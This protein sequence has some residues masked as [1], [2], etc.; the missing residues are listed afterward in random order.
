MFNINAW[1]IHTNIDVTEFISDKQ[2]GKQPHKVF[3][4]EI[5]KALVVDS[6]KHGQTLQMLWFHTLTVNCTAQFSFFYISTVDA[7][8]M[9]SLCAR[10]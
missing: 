9:R 1:S 8:L 4:I 7:T 10:S 2:K 3:H 5:W 6:T